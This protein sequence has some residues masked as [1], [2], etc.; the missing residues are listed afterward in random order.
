MRKINRIVLHHTA[1]ARLGVS[2]HDI[3]YMHLQRGWSDI[4]YHYLVQFPA[5]EKV[6]VCV[7]RPE[8]LM[9]AHLRGHNTDTIGIAVAGNYETDAFP[10]HAMQPV[11]KLVYDLCVRYGLTADDVYAHR[12]LAA[13]LCPGAG[14]PLDQIRDKVRSHGKSD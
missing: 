10:S 2:V 7:G 9:G 5:S 6:E 4:G 3:R 14:F 13:T 11:V 12:E 8:R 1:T